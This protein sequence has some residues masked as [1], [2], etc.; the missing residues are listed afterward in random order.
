MAENTGEDSRIV[1][2]DGVDLEL[3]ERGRG[4]P[5]LFLH[6]GHPTGRLAPSAPILRHLSENFRVIAPTHPG[7]GQA[8]APENLNSVDDLAYLYLDLLD[9]LNLEQ[10]TL[11]G[12][13]LGGWIAAE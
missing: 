1:S 8:P 9:A 10:V 3:T 12:V 5:L 6:G 7:F 4:A 13:S 11:V 2:L